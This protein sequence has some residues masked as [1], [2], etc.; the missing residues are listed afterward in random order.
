MSHPDCVAGLVNTYPGYL[1]GRG[2][3]SFTVVQ[4][5]YSTASA[6]RKAIA[7][8]EMMDSCLSKIHWYEF[9]RKQLHPR[10]ELESPTPFLTMITVALMSEL[11]PIS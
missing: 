7:G 6:D 2:S 10:F 1:L 9:R 11:L 8:G 4:S 3:Y 5:S